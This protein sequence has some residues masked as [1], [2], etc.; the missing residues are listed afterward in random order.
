MDFATLMGPG[1]E[2]LGHDAARR[3]Q[4]MLDRDRA[5][6]VVADFDIRRADPPARVADA[7]R[8]VVAARDDAA[9][10]AMQAQSWSRQLV[11]T[12]QGEAG[13]FDKVYDQYRHAPD[14]TRRQMY[15]ATME[16]V[17][18]QSDKV[19]VDAPGT[20]MALPQPAPIQSAPK[21]GT[22][23]GPANGH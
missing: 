6:I 15:Y 17:L 16:R 1:R 14:V 11:A 23:A 9:T 12:A 2:T 7:L 5:G 10:E 8:A 22:D 18:A 21:T 20:T 13:A 4:V 19:I 3:L